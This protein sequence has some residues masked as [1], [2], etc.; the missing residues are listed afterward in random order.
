MVEKD[1]RFKTIVQEYRNL[2]TAQPDVCSSFD[3]LNENFSV[4]VCVHVLLCLQAYVCV[5]MHACRT[6]MLSYMQAFVYVCLS[7]HVVSVLYV[8]A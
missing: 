2:P 8:H 5:S 7:V 4:C 6:S 1:I 3:L